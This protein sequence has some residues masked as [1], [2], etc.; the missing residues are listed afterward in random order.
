MLGTQLTI[1]KARDLIKK[2]M[3]ESVGEELIGNLYFKLCTLNI[4]KKNLQWVESVVEIYE[5]LYAKVSKA[6]LS[7]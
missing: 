5:S 1:A 4:D 6:V 7:T 2:N 3:N